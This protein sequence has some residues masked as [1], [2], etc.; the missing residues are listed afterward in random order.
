MEQNSKEVTGRDAL[1][2]T[3]TGPLTELSRNVQDDLASRLVSTFKL[4]A[5]EKRLRIFLV[6]MECKEMNVRGLCE[7]L[8]QSQP[9]VSHHLALMRNANFVVYR[10]DGKQSFYRIV[11]ENLEKVIATLFSTDVGQAAL[12]QFHKFQI[13]YHPRQNGICEDDDST[14]PPLIQDGLRDTI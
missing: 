13:E 8:G 7:K 6:L 14:F 1:I 9:A 12:L 3:E 5:D 4:F 2:P 10:R 11:P